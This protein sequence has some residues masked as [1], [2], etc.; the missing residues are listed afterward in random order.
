MRGEKTVK[1]FPSYRNWRTL[2]SLEMVTAKELGR[3]TLY[4]AVPPNCTFWPLSS[5]ESA[6]VSVL[7]SKFSSVRRWA[8]ILSSAA[9]ASGSTLDFSYF[10]VLG[11]DCGLF[12][13]EG[14]GTG[15][16]RQ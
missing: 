6:R 1:C 2:R 9:R 7:I 10:S 16:E 14:C 12:E 11:T 8:P 3:R 13:S 4:C 15:K 5:T